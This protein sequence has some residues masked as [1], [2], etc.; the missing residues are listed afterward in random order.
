VTLL[1]ERRVSTC[2]SCRRGWEVGS[3][4]T[5]SPSP[6]RRRDPRGPGVNRA[7][8]WPARSRCALHADDGPENLLDAGPLYA[9]ETVVRIG[10]VSPAAELVRAL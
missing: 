9:G 10:D 4:A 8:N 3:A 7:L 1:I 5:S 6:S 2:R